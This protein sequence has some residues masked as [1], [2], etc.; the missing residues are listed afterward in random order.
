MS[1]NEV[2][3]TLSTYSK[4]ENYDQRLNTF[5][6]HFWPISIRQNGTT[7]AKAGFFYQGFGDIV[8]CAFCGVS[9]HKWL[10]DDDPIVEHRKFNADCKFI[11]LLQDCNIPRD[12]RSCSFYWRT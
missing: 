11:R 9:L 3:W 1:T 4:Y 6:E 10:R 8:T 7:M 12:N 5:F 2:S